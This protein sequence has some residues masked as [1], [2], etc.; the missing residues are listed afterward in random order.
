MHSFTFLHLLL[1][2]MLM[3][4]PALSRA[5]DSD[6]K[7]EIIKIEDQSKKPLEGRPLSDFST[8]ELKRL[9]VAERARV[10]IALPTA[11]TEDDVRQAIAQAVHDMTVQ[12]PGLD[13]IS[14]LI[15]STKEQTESLADLGS[16]LWA[17]G[18][19]LGNLTARIAAGDKR[20][21]YQLVVDVNRDGLEAAQ[22][23]NLDEKKLGLTEQQR[24]EIFTAMVQA[25]DKSRIEADKIYPTNPDCVPQS[26]LAENFD[27]NYESQNKFLD[28]YKKEIIVKFNITEKIVAEI[29]NEARKEQWPLPEHKF[30]KGHGC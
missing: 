26:K 4:F 16:A 3:I 22:A 15:Y 2:A 10:K 1:I 7:Y 28:Q 21:G 18:G 17:P 5:Q 13:A 11:K 29:K 19:K 23:R 20:E 14:F 24:R 25:E 30:L 8:E 12:R 6:I 9:P 27:K